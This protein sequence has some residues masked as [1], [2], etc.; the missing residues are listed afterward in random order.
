MWGFYWWVYCS[1]SAPFMVN[2]NHQHHEMSNWNSEY[3]ELG[4]IST[5]GWLLHSPTLYNVIAELQHVVCLVIWGRLCSRITG[6]P[7]VWILPKLPVYTTA[8]RFCLVARAIKISKPQNNNQV[9]K[10]VLQQCIINRATQIHQWY[11]C[12]GNKIVDVCASWVNGFQLELPQGIP[13][14]PAWESIT[15]VNL[16]SATP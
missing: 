14:L 1:N 2:M 12:F 9:K 10:L 4:L 13:L 6:G 11:A 5:Y 16:I 3:F 7:C 15:A 8:T